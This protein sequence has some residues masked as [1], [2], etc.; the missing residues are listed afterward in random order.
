MNNNTLT[1]SDLVDV[2]KIKEGKINMV[3]AGCGT[4]KSYFA[5]KTLP[6]KLN[7]RPEEILVVTSRTI[8][9]DQ[10]KDDKK[11]NIKEVK[12]KDLYLY[13]SAIEN[14]SLNNNVRRL[15]NHERKVHICT[16]NYFSQYILESV[17]LPGI[18]VIIFDE[19]HSL[20]TDIMYNK[21]L[22]NVWENIDTLIKDKTIIGMTAT[23]IEIKENRKLRR[24]LNY[25]LD[26]PY[27][28]YQVQ[29]TFN[30][31]TKTRYMNNILNNL[32]GNTLYMTLSTKDALRIG[33]RENTQYIISQYNKL[34][35]TSMDTIREYIKTNKVLP[36]N[37]NM[38]VGTSC[39]REGFEFKEESNIK[40]VI[41]ESSDPNMIIQFIG[42]YRGNIDNVYIVYNYYSELKEYQNNLT[43][44]QKI[45][46]KEFKSLIKNNN[47]KWTK[48][49]TN[50]V[51]KDSIEFNIIKDSNMQDSFLE[52]INNNWIDKLIYTKEDKEIIVN[53]ATEYGLKKDK[54]HN[55]S[56]NSLMKY[57]ESEDYAI[58]K[59]TKRIKDKHTRTIMLTKM[60][61]L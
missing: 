8:T 4:G 22:L 42:R 23:D 37:I 46:H 41:I 52:Y 45:Y 7:V 27:Y 1:V 56:F 40:N 17:V 10:Q 29:K 34:N 49:F 51:N 19:I 54:T 36:D 55:H 32:K 20:L 21:T 53:K 59:K 30:I 18:K 57:L 28:L 50:I 58:Q 39:I 14:E 13:Y 31:I 48:Y 33:Q 6:E 26:E 35:D 61:T 38:L 47:M 9:K 60:V 25:L 44:A 3:V 16:Y 2:D 5:F 24:K 15:I 12:L 11:Y 43:H